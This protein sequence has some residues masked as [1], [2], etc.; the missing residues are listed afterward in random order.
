MPTIGF[1]RESGRAAGT[2]LVAAVLAD[3]RLPPVT[4]TL[5]A[6]C[7]GALRRLRAAGR[8]SGGAGETAIV[9][10]PEGLEAERLV[11]LGL[12]APATLD[13][14]GWERAGGA[15]AAALDG[16]GAGRVRLVLDP[17]DDAAMAGGR[18]LAH[19]ATGFVLRGTRDDRFRSRP[20]PDDE[21]APDSL[22]LVSAFADGARAAWE[23]DLGP[24]AEGVLLAR[25]LFAEPANTLYPESFVERLAPLAA[26]GIDIEAHGPDKLAAL[27]MNAMLAV[28]RGSARGPRLVV[29]RWNGA[30]D[31]SAPPLAFVGK[32]ITFDSGG[33]SLKP[34][35]G[36]EEMKG[37]MAG[38]A[39]VVGALQALAARRAPVNAVGVLGLA[40]NMP[41]ADAYRP[42]DILKTMAGWTIEVVDTDAEGRLVLADALWF[43]QGTFRPQAMVDLATLTYDIIK[44]LGLVFTG[45]FASDDTLAADLL[46]A[47]AISGE[48]LWRMPLDAAFEEHL[49]SEVADLRHFGEDIEGADASHA[50]Q[51]LSRFAGDRPW[52]H[53]DI[54]GKEMAY[55]DQTLCPKG[56]TGVG[57]RL[58]DQFAR[59][60]EAPRA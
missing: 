24:V 36:M 54:A 44:G 7:G 45:L 38:A 40:E 11:L 12:G 59:R 17:P 3:R 43:T 33:I 6:A 9:A 34:G 31:P 23:Q 35:K 56:P 57:V 42:G 20:R 29:L 46:A 32:G 39:A 51:L 26:L 37:D 49:G 30:P 21:G 1:E 13:H 52:A 27:G 18:A 22:V 25:R 8:F 2:T 16:T 50:T 60:R 55:E 15:L 4:A 47:S 14:H 48:K 19:L 58:L 41:G 53:L 5:D 28:G 10:A